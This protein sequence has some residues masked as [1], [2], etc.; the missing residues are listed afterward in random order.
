MILY[1]CDNG[2]VLKPLIILK[3]TFPLLDEIEAEYLSSEV[4][5]SKTKKES[6]ELE[7]FT[8]WS[9]HSIIPHKEKVNRDGISLLILD[10]HGSRFSTDTIDLC[11]KNKIEILAYP[12]HLTHVLQG[13]EVVLNRR[14]KTI[15]DN[16]VHN[17]L[18]VSGT[19]IT[20]LKSLLLSL[21]R[22]QRSI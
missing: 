7:L 11:I 16:F 14:I 17:H 5:L 9:K 15:V 8:D 6:M 12:G 1:I 21:T 19:T 10:N 3:K 20:R 4:L 2:D 13:P 18:L 22:P